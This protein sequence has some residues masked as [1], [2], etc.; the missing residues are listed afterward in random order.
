[1]T[2]FLTFRVMLVILCPLLISLGGLAMAE[3]GGRRQHTWSAPLSWHEARVVDVA[4]SLAT[5]GQAPMGRADWLLGM[6]EPVLRAAA[7]DPAL[8]V[9]LRQNA[10]QALEG[11][12]A[13]RAEL[14]ARPPRRGRP[15]VL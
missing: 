6:A 2:P 9:A 13:E 8:P 15:P 12:Q 4:R 3:R 5:V 1:M 11:L 14:A 7:I 10:R